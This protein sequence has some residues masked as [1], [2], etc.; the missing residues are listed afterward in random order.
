MGQLYFIFDQKWSK[1]G[2]NTR[3]DPN[4]IKMKKLTI[5]LKVHITHRQYY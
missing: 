1:L 3:I 2:A 4:N 5:F